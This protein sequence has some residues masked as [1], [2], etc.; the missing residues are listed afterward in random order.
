MTSSKSGRV[1]TYEIAPGSLKP[2]EGWMMEQRTV[3]DR[4]LNQLDRF[5]YQLKKK[6][7]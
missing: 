6:I 7:K 4:R 1:R 3:W 5:L 2:A